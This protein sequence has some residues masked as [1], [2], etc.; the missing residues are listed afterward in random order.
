M[1]NLTENEEALEL[2]KT[3]KVAIFFEVGFKK[4][5]PTTVEDIESYPAVQTVALPLQ[6]VDG[7][8]YSLSPANVD[9]LVSARNT[10]D[11]DKAIIKL[12]LARYDDGEYTLS[13]HMEY[14]ESPFTHNHTLLKD[15]LEF[16]NKQFENIQHDY[17]GKTNAN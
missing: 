5:E 10:C 8:V 1:I 3:N 11:D 14:K 17:V 7:G 13:H 15:Y 4:L 9:N 12:T 16:F 2:V 6:I